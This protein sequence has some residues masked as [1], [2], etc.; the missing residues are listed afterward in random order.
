MPAR[1]PMKA[2]FA[3]TVF[4]AMTLAAPSSANLIYVGI[5]D[6]GGGVGN[7]AIVLS[8]NSQ[9]NATIESGAVVPD[10]GGGETCSG[11]TQSPCGSPSNTTPTF[12]DLG[13][14]S[15]SDFALYLDAQETDNLITITSLRLDV[16][17][18]T[19]SV[20]NAS[21][22]PVPVTLVTD[23]GQG[24]NEV[25]KFILDAAQAA[26]LQAVIDSYSLSTLQIGLDGTLTSVSGG[27]ERFIAGVSS[28]TVPEPLSLALFGTGLIGMGL[29]LRG[30]RA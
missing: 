21:L 4:G 3:S 17:S 15:A 7:S 2:L 8:L 6:L 29:A 10:S 27:P 19:T 18:G 30:R 1:I 16:F 22:E 9:G 13:V 24:T 5:V 12:S 14:T 11:D 23:S 25:N 26:A 28:A 20:F